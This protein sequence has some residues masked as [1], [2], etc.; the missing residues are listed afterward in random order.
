MKI[1]DLGEI[2][3]TMEIFQAWKYYIVPMFAKWYEQHGK[4]KFPSSEIPD[5]QFRL[6]DNEED[7]EIFVILPDGYEIS[8]FVPKGHWTWSYITNN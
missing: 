8:L 6:A 5:E 4:N 2:S 1:Y 3:V 7:G